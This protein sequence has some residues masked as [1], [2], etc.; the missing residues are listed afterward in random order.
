MSKKNGGAALIIGGGLALAALH[1]AS[2]AASSSP[3]AR[4]EAAA[5]FPASGNV[6]LGRSLAASD[7]GW[8]GQ[9][10]TCLYVL[11]QGESGWSQYADTR[12]SGLDASNAAVF[13][14]GIPQ[15]RPATKMPLAAQPADLG[16]SS[17]PGAQIQ[18][19]LRYIHAEYGTPCAALGFKRSHGNQGY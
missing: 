5:A 2:G 4:V 19:G 16:G 7:Y 3:P 10:F 8:R 9:Q 11:W 17:D 15:S 6:A 1:A 18:W 13:A 14:Y 12:K